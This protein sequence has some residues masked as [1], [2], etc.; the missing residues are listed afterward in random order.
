MWLLQDAEL[1]FGADRS[2]RTVAT[3]NGSHYLTLLRAIAGSVFC[4]RIDNNWRTSQFRVVQLTRRVLYSISV[5]S[6]LISNFKRHVTVTPGRTLGY[7]FFTNS[8]THYPLVYV[9]AYFIIIFFCIKFSSELIKMHYYCF[10]GFLK[11]LSKANEWYILFKIHFIS[12]NYLSR[13]YHESTFRRAAPRLER[14]TCIAGSKPV[15]V[16]FFPPALSQLL[17]VVCL[18]NCNDLSSN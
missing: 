12:C 17:S 13:E 9:E 7:L 6:I 3:S 5:D 15:E 18:A 1:F 8:I 16:W 11:V 14:C 10:L 2:V 4:H